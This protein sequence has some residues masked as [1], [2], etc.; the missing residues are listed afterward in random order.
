MEQLQEVIKKDLI[1]HP[2][3]NIEIIYE[4]GKT[5]FTAED[6]ALIGGY[7]SLHDLEL[8]MKNTAGKLHHQSLSVNETIQGLRE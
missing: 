6:E 5:T 3:R 4:A 8:E 1:T 7:T 2:L